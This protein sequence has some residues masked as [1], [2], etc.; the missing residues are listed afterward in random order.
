MIRKTLLAATI[1]AGA[2]LTISTPAM[3]GGWRHSH[4]CGCGHSTCE[5]SSGGSTSTSGGSTSSGGSEVPEPGMVGILGLG[6]IGMA[7][8][9]RRRVYR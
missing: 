3:A 9:R 5:S 2:L 1:A 4:Y 8:A 6:L 7:Y